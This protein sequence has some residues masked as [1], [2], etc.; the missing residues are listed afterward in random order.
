MSEM[1]PQSDPRLQGMRR[2]IWIVLAVALIL[3]LWGVVSRVR[4]RAA[5]A[6]A[7]AAAAIP[8]VTTVAAHAKPR[9]G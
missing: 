2:F 3:A 1:P 9:D 5:L 4:S 7:T 6:H 8:V